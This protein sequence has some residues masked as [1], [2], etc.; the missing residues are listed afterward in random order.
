[1]S[2]DDSQINR[3]INLLYL[4]CQKN[5]KVMATS[6]YIGRGQGLQVREDESRHEQ[7][8]DIPGW[9]AESKP[10]SWVYALEE[11]EK[12]KLKTKTLLE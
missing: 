2:P 7:S 8:P 11:K 9:E 6:T 4:E 10:R 5:M 1:M 12:W 3:L